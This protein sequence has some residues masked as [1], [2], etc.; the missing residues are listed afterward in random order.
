MQSRQDAVRLEF[1][2]GVVICTR[3]TNREI[4]KATGDYAQVKHEKIV[5]LSREE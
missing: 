2:K 5:L 1:I 4:S 3:T